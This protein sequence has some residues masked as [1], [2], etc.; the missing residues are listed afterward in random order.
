MKRCPTCHTEY[1]DNASFCTQ[2]LAALLRVVCRALARRPQKRYATAGEFGRAVSEAPLRRAQHLAEL[3][4]V[5]AD[6]TRVAMPDVLQPTKDSP[7]GSEGAPRA[8]VARRLRRGAFGDTGKA[9]TLVD[10]PDSRSLNEAVQAL[11]DSM[12]DVSEGRRSY[13]LWASRI[14]EQQALP[15]SLR[16]RAA[17]M[18]AAGHLADGELREARE[19]SV[20]AYDLIPES[21]DA[22]RSTVKAQIDRLTAAK[23]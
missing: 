21:D 15:D 10:L 16:I 23:D 8:P 3:T 5:A 18:A 17:L 13:R 12:F 19:W 1:P 20:R 6:A 4:A 11:Q 9:P 2:D 14:F 7:I 22:M